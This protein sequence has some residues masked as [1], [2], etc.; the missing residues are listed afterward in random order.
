[1]LILD[2]DHHTPA[3]LKDDTLVQ[4]A[5]HMSK[6]VLVV[7][8]TAEHKKDG[9]G[10]MLLFATD[11]TSPAYAAHVTHDAHGR[12]LVQIVEYPSGVETVAM[13]AAI[14][15]DAERTALL[16][17][18][19][20]NASAASAFAATLVERITTPAHPEVRTLTDTPIPA[21]VAYAQIAV[22]SRVSYVIQGSAADFGRRGGYQHPNFEMDTTFTVILNNHDDPRGDFQW[23]L[24]DSEVTANPK[25]EDED[26]L[27]K[28][29][30]TSGNWSADWDEWGFFQTYWKH[31]IET[32]MLANPNDRLV[33][34]K[35]SPQTENSMTEVETGTDIEIGYTAEGGPGASVGFS[36]S[37]TRDITDWQITNES[38]DNVASWYYRSQYPF[39]ND[40]EG[41]C[42][43][44]RPCKVGWTFGTSYCA[45]E[46]YRLCYIK[47]DPNALSMNA[48]NLGTQATYRTENPDGSERLVDGW[49][50]FTITAEHGVI[51]LFCWDDLAFGC[52]VPL[53]NEA[54]AQITP[55]YHLNLGGIIPL[56]VASV[57]FSPDPVAAGSKVTGT[58]TLSEPSLLHTH[59]LLSSNNKTN[60]PVQA[61]VDIA[62]GTTSVDFDFDTTANG[63]PEGGSVDAIITAYNELNP[64]V[65]A[66]GRLTITR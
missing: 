47:Q 35:T 40:I 15:P 57:T 56:Q 16:A 45:Q 31:R 42:W 3:V 48:L 7:D 23:V 30:H 60:A 18:Q 5:L 11:G 53:D 22:T 21:A 49:A 24:V 51:D 62:P 33:L 25:G 9:L 52:A 61:K 59:V 2:G 41:T 65:V 50:N 13:P 27:A 17:S 46:I 10:D 54:K 55:T 36:S 19:G 12:P 29:V 34:L 63:I 64:T 39:D 28:Q 14:P 66:Q 20:L 1:M 26:F 6:W 44:G 43:D 37:T 4:E 8:A 38:A 58:V 32:G